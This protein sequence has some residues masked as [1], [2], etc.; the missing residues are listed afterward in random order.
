MKKTETTKRTAAETLIE[1]AGEKHAQ[2]IILPAI[3][4]EYVHSI[5]GMFRGKV[6]LK[7]LMEDR[8]NQRES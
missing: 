8:K 7:A 3:T 5:R 1:S 2:E 6:L 4:R